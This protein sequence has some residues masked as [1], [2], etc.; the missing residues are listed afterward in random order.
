MGGIKTHD[1]KILLR[2]PSSLTA[3]I[4]QVISEQFPELNRSEFIRRAVR[5]CLDNVEQF[6]TSEA[7]TVVESQEI[8]SVAKVNAVRDQYKQ[9]FEYKEMMMREKATP[10]DA[11]QIA[12]LIFLIAEMIFRQNE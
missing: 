3:A 8:E 1:D 9:I 6:K 12:F 10:N 4:D 2:L 7:S 5:F 11:K